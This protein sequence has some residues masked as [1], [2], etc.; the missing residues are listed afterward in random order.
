MVEMTEKVYV[1]IEFGDMELRVVYS[2]G[3]ETLAL[4]LPPEIGGAQILF[5]ANSGGSSIGVGF[6]TVWQKLGTHFSFTSMSLKVGHELQPYQVEQST[7]TPQSRIEYTLATIRQNVLKV[8]GKP[9]GGAVIAVPAM[10][11]QNGRQALLDCARSAGFEGV[12]LIDRSTAA[13]LGYQ[14]DCVDKSTTALVCDLGYGDCEYSLLRLVGERCRV[15]NSGGVPDVSGEALDSLIIEATVLALRMKNIYLG[16]KH[17]TPF[18]WLELRHIIANARQTLAEN[19]EAHITLIPKLTGLDKP[20]KFRYDG[21]AFKN[22]LAA[23]INRIVDGVLGILEQSALELSDVDTILLVGSSARTSP[24]SDLLSEAFEREVT[25]GEPYL[26]ARG[27]VRHAGQ[28]TRGSVEHAEAEPVKQVAP[29][30]ESPA[31][32]ASA[33]QPGE[34]NSEAH[35]K[36]AVLVDVEDDASEQSTLKQRTAF[37]ISTS[38]LSLEIV[39]K[40]IEHGRREE[41]TMLLDI[42]GREVEALREKLRQDEK[43]DVPRMLIQQ[44]LSLVASGYELLGAVDLTHR[45]YGQA[46]DDP[47]VFEG[48]LKVHAEAGLQMSSPDKYDTSIK[49]LL[50]AL[51]HDQTDRRVRQALAE[52]YYQHALTLSKQ[53][54][55]SGAFEIVDKALAYDAR[56][57]G[58]NQLHKELAANISNPQAVRKTVESN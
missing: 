51:S 9:L 35:A 14:S 26:I 57:P 58:L 8:T 30:M 55:W 24:V 37:V 22:Q 12:R 10:M 5:E 1:G 29:P 47:E 42:M 40:F 54:D 32:A 23:L 45:A 11:T 21:E 3:S 44:A 39:R 31:E 50:C 2:V 28:I 27:A 52:R 38:D 19:Q 41:A 17:F 36:F 6:P 46:P 56:H 15:M 53:D 49:V 7:E 33:A 48:M 25:R 18:Q 4:P 16:L 34:N 43:H 20:I 13:A